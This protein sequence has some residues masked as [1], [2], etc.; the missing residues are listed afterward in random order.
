MNQ[1]N[2]KSIIISDPMEV[3]PDPLQGLMHITS[4]DVTGL[5][6]LQKS[7][8]TLPNK[9]Y[10][11]NSRQPNNKGQ[12]H[13]G[14]TTMAGPQTQAI[15]GEQMPY[16]SSSFTY[17][18]KTNPQ[19]LSRILGAIEQMWQKAVTIFPDE[20]TFMMQTNPTLRL[21]NTGFH[22]ISSGTN[23]DAL[24]HKDDTNLKHS[25]QCVLVLGE[26][27]GGEVRFDVSGRDGKNR[28]GFTKSLGREEDVVIVP[29]QHGT[30]FIGHY[31]QLWHAVNKVET[32]NRTILAAY[33]VQKVTDFATA[34]EGRY[35]FQEAEDLRYH[36]CAVVTWI[37]QTHPGRINKTMRESIRK[38]LTEEWKAI[39]LA[40]PN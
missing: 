3:E 23:L 2:A 39:D 4:M 22:K 32:G 21:G 8:M 19:L 27:T 36:R 9:L 17:L 15:C 1:L 14:W 25:I 18:A 33:A 10:K 37:K 35:T 40:G 28:S 13:L 24:W 7:I 5:G 20:T 34:I 26:F 11:K 31:E 16:L 30:L 38:P 29:N 6:G 12:V